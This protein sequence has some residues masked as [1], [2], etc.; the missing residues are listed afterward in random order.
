MELSTAATINRRG[1]DPAVRTLRHSQRRGLASPSADDSSI[2]QGV[3]NG[4]AATKLRSIE[5]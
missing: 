3:V 5:T 1:R 2:G 4:R